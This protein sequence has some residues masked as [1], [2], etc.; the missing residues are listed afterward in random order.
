MKCHRNQCRLPC[1]IRF[2]LADGLCTL[3]E[4][5]VVNIVW[6]WDSIIW[7][8]VSESIGLAEVLRTTHHFL[9]LIMIRFSPVGQISHRLLLT[10]IWI[11]YP[12]C[13]YESLTVRTLHTMHT[14]IRISNDKTRAVRLV[15][16][17]EHYKEDRRRCVN[18]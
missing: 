14:L 16:L 18:S 3:G 17:K 7:R 10:E 5:P 8:Y 12:A 1:W 11:P 6:F 15:T 9:V 4:F 2:G 13:V